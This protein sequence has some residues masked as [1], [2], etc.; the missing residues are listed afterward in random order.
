[1]SSPIIT[2]TTNIPMPFMLDADGRSLLESV[3]RLL[4]R[5]Q[6]PTLMARAQLE[7]YTTEEHQVGWRAF[8]E[9]AGGNTTVELNVASGVMQSADAL[10]TQRR[11]SILQQL[12][13]MENTWF[14]RLRAIIRRVLAD[15]PSAAAFEAAFFEE[16]EQQPLG[17][18]VIASMAKFV[19]R[20]RSLD[21]TPGSPGAR[22]RAVLNERGLTDERLAEVSA[23][24]EELQAFAAGAVDVGQP[25]AAEVAAI[26]ARRAAAFAKVERWY[27]DWAT[28]FRTV[29]ST[30]EQLQLGLTD[31]K[32]KKEKKEKKAVR[33]ATAPVVTPV[34]P[35]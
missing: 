31:L 17:P 2:I 11:N 3:A 16:M 20:I 32:G 7:G 23:M 14:P 6:Q 18:G 26:N 10:V 21:T 22:V 5:I 4:M 29:F 1:M 12:D 25:T 8:V 13:G 27:Q 9:A 28:T 35:A 15:D 19:N 33:D 34:L 24:V 30:R